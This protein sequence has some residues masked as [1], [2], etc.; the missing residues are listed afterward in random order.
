MSV[1]S[2]TA[3]HAR[4]QRVK[5]PTAP[6]HALT[7]KTYT[8]KTSNGLTTCIMDM[9][10]FDRILN[11]RPVIAMRT[12]NEG[13]YRPGQEFVDVIGRGRQMKGQWLPGLNK[14]MSDITITLY[15]RVYYVEIKIGKD[16]QKPDQ[17]K[18]M[19]TVRNG[20]ATYEIVKTFEDFY[21]LYT[22][23]ITRK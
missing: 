6:R 12:G 2:L 9:C 8:D 18:F 1:K 20:G 13:R 23:W 3:I 16:R 4:A 10:E 19:N 5:Y 7:S 21:S 15:G 22:T 17:I 14:G 11:G